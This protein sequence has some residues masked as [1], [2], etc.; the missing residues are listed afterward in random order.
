MLNECWWCRL[1]PHTSKNYLVTWF[2]GRN[3][4]ARNGQ[5]I[6]CGC[7]SFIY[8]HLQVA[9]LTNGSVEGVAKP[10]LT[11]GGAIQLLRGPL[12]DINM[13]QVL[14]A[15]RL[16]L[17]EDCRECYCSCIGGCLVCIQSCDSCDSLTTLFTYLQ[18][19]CRCVC[20]HLYVLHAAACCCHP[21]HQSWKPFPSSYSYAVKQLGVG[22]KDKVLM[23]A[24]HPWDIAGAMQVTM[25][26]DACQGR[27]GK[28][29]AGSACY[30]LQAKRPPPLLCRQRQPDTCRSVSLLHTPSRL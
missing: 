23:V 26:G 5:H 12:L 17:Q 20:I 13:A 10:A 9:V 11:A 6:T 29:G 19:P 8:Q 25:K 2:G 7:S 28:M 4:F 30:Y 27:E 22:D 16:G 3:P 18:P 24:S 21:S 1:Q 14:R 15:G